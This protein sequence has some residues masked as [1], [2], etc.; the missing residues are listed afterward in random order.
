MAELVSPNTEE[1]TD[2]MLDHI[3]FKQNTQIVVDTVLGKK[4]Y[5]LLVH[6]VDIVLGKKKYDLLDH[7]KLQ[8]T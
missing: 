4:K 3:M 2:D 6:V 5:D 1:L 8:L 7:G